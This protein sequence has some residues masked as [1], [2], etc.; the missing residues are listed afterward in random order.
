MKRQRHLYPVTLMARVLKVSRSGFYAWLTRPPSSRSVSDE[1]MKPLIRLAH[2][3]GR[4]TYGPRRIQTE[5]QANGITVGR[6]RIA[7]LRREMSL[8]CIQKRKF[9]ATTN[10]AHSLPVVANLLN[11]EFAVSEPGTVYGTDI[12]YVSTDEGWL[13]LAGV[14]DLATRELIGYAMGSRMTKELTH[15]ALNRAVRYRKPQPGC[16]HHSDRGSQYCAITY[17]C[18]VVALGMRPSMSR[19][20]NC[21][22]NAPVESF[23]GALKEELIYHRRFRTRVEA[24]AAIQ[25]YIEVFYNRMRRHSALGNVAPA[26]FAENHLSIRRSA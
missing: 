19:K 16:I 12:T 2:K 20:G 21:Y 1:K 26:I 9:K 14:K 6:D 5:L 15:A 13:Y 10:S 7:R 23:W 11:Q 4:G 24:Q 22:D 25:E 17:Q 18:A 8:R 3:T